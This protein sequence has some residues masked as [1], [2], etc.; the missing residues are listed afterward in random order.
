MENMINQAERAEAKGSFYFTTF[1]RINEK[2]VLRDPIWF[3]ADK[4]ES[5]PL[6][7]IE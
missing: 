5:V 3:R 4:E 6:F 1:D 7:F 2:T